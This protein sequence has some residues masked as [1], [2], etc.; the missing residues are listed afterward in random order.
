[1]C[2]AAHHLAALE[3]IEAVVEEVLGEVAAVAGF[4]ALF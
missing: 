1:M 2:A 4:F 3:A